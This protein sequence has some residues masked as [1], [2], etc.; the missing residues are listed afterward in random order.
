MQNG[1]N[2]RRSTVFVVMTLLFRRRNFLVLF[3]LFRVF[4]G[5][6]ESAKAGSIE[7]TVTFIG[8]IPKSTTTDDAGRRHDLLEVDGKTRGLRYVALYL[9]RADGSTVPSQPGARAARPTE[10]LLMDQVDYAFTPRLLAVQEGEA[11]TF[12]NSDPANHNVRTTASNKTNEFN[13]FTGVDGKYEHKFR[14]EPRYRPVRLGCDIHPWMRAWIFVF[15]HPWFAVTDE[16]GRFSISDVTPG[17][18]RLHVVQ[19][20]IAHREQRTVRVVANETVKL[21]IAIRRGA[22]KH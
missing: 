10:K 1:P 3:V 8:E 2:K 20:D 14:I 22:T 16:T 11:V 19:P 5:T 4:A 12:A 9:T 18:F 6:A 15:D 7:G 13:V 17:E 21:E